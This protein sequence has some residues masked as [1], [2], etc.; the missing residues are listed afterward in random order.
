MSEYLS[1]HSVKVVLDQQARALYFSRAP[2][3]HARSSTSS[4]PL[5]LPRGEAVA[6]GHIGI[7]GYRKEALGRLVALPPSPLEECEKLEQLRALQAGMSIGV[8]LVAGTAPG[9]D[10]KADLEAFR[11]RYRKRSDGGET[12]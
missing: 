4:E 8:A 3:P 1:P 12:S 7:Y 2:I 11:E 5:R 9:I 10:T 6:L